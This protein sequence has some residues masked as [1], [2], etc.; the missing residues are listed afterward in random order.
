MWGIILICVSARVCLLHLHCHEDVDEFTAC[1][2]EYV[3]SGRGSVTP[4]PSIPATGASLFPMVSVAAQPVSGRSDYY[5]HLLLKAWSSERG[6]TSLTLFLEIK[7]EMKL[8]M[9]EMSHMDVGSCNKETN[10]VIKGA[11]VWGKLSDSICFLI[12]SFSQ[13]F[14]HNS[15]QFDRPCLQRTTGLQLR[16]L[17]GAAVWELWHVRVSVGHLMLG[18]SYPDSVLVAWGVTLAPRL[19]P[20]GPG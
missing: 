8:L 4:S 19:S 14:Q 9:T 10:A 20:A 15:G 16:F 13:E 18:A 7:L 11:V 3:Q 12:I 1:L 17:Y 6:Q 5:C 2:D